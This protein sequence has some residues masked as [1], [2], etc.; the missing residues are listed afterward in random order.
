MCHGCDSRGTHEPE[1]DL[2]WREVQTLLDEELHRLPVQH[3]VPL[4]LCCLEGVTRD[5][6]AQQL[7]WSLSTLKRRLE[8]GRELLRLRLVRRGLTLSAALFTPMLMQS[9][10]QAALTVTLVQA[11]VRSAL[12]LAVGQPVAGLVS[13]QVAALVDGGLKTMLTTKLKVATAL[14]LA[15]SVAAGAGAL[16]RQALA[17]KTGDP[18]AEKSPKNSKEQP[19]P[20]EIAKPQG[21]AGDLVYSGR[22]LGPDGKP[23]A[24][25][26]LFVTLPW[27]YMQRPAPSPVRATTGTDGRFQFTASKSKFGPHVYVMA[28]VAVAPGYG[29]DWVE[30]RPQDAKDD[31][32]L[33]L[34]KDDVPI[35]GQV[36]DLQG[37]PVRG[38]TVRVLH[39]QAAP[40]DDLSSWIQAVKAKKEG[41][42]RLERDY[43]SRQLMSQEIAAL[44]QKVTTDADGRFRITGIGRER[45]LAVQIEGPAIATKQVR[46]LTRPGEVIEVPEWKPML[47]PGLE[48]PSVMT[49]YGASFK[50]AA[51][52]TKPIIGVVRDKD[53]KKPLAGA[54][55]QSYKLASSPMHGIDFIKT[56]TDEHG[57]YRLNGM[58]KGEGNKIMVVPP[59]DQPY[60][61][62]QTEVSDS[63][64]LDPVTVDFEL[65]HGVW[66]E[67]KV[68]DKVT[69]KSLHAKVEYFS[70][71]PN[72]HL[73]DYP[74]FHSIFFNKS[75]RNARE[76]G[77][78]R[79]IGIPGPGVLAVQYSDL[80]LLAHERDDEYGTKNAVLNTAPHAL[81]IISYNAVAP[82]VVNRDHNPAKRDV[83]LDP[84]QT[85]K[86]TVLDPDGKPLAGARAYGLSGWGGW[87]RAVLEK[88][89]FTVQAFNLKRPRPVVFQHLDK[90]LVGILAS[91][92]KK[93]DKVTVKL[94]PGAT[95]TGRLVDVD[96]QPRANVEL[97]L[98]FRGPK[99]YA[100]AQYFPNKIKTD[101]AGRFKLNALLPGYRFDLRDPNGW[102]YF[103]ETL[104]S[105]ETEDL[106]DVQVKRGDG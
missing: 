75:Y 105:G 13:E 83:T 67:G 58:P 92:K 39:L 34:V 76:D 85:F 63:P 81:A 96:G 25:A 65:K 91:P 43:L 12:Q 77:T 44:P 68:T 23:V 30:V 3:R 47:E 78:F 11:T 16:T 79:V 100:W 41:C 38:A 28:V 89:D 14:L 72:P 46:I 54:T 98:T 35:N 86:G 50:H 69:G 84:G 19:A 66:I 29:P 20:K 71:V 80:Y 57:R 9:T 53:T 45:M 70:M 7:G 21:A 73:R 26:K 27:S 62:T 42:H 36:L 33:R 22:V 88:A 40:K 17:G 102:F 52:P 60:L 55:I 99:D 64:G 31:L 32:T 82:I 95:V 48:K 51:G 37:R 101:E 8:R 61:L 74:G 2:S 94:Q 1:D 4:V 49:Y 106:G 24:G 18:P 6:A 10:A 93:T 104:R 87:D 56:T 59:D 5:E 90:G 15:V 97:D 103:G